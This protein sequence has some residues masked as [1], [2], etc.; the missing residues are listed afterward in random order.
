M[1]PEVS[2]QADLTTPPA[3]YPHRPLAWGHK[4][5]LEAQ[6]AGVNIVDPTE[7][8]AATETQVEE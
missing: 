7:S 8:V 3:T 5:G 1:M 6:V 2:S 4:I